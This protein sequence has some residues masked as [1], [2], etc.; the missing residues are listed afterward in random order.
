[1]RRSMHWYIMREASTAPKPTRGALEDLADRQYA[2][3][4][5][6][7]ADLESQYQEQCRLARELDIAISG[8][9]NAAEQ[10]SLCDL[11]E[12]A[13]QLRADLDAALERVEKLEGLIVAWDEIERMAEAFGIGPDL[14]ASVATEAER[15]RER[16]Q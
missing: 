16:G 11:I 13:R 15:I 2:T 10:A 3:I 7:R 1:M 14:A 12:P 9:E 6:L 4:V 5:E 8:A